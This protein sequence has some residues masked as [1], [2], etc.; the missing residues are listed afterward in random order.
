MSAFGDQRIAAGT[1]YR[2][3]TVTNVNH[4]SKNDQTDSNENGRRNFF[5]RTAAGIVGA[6]CG[7]VPFLAG[8]TFLANPILDSVSADGEKEFLPLGIGPD[9]LPAD[10]TPVA[11]QVLS[12]RSDAWNVYPD[13]PIGSIWLRRT[14]SGEIAAFNT[15]CPHLGCYVDYRSGSGDFFCP[16][17]TSTFD[18]EGKRLNQIPPR[19]MDSLELQERDGKLWVRFQNFRGA[20]TEKIAV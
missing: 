13:E 11:V 4:E 8:L 6:V 2:T 16:C 10:G 20:T 17:H 18:L 5:Q 19:D 14:L 1:V 3:G 15:I 7:L 9:A 12:D